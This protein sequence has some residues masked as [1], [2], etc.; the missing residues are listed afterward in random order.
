[1]KY[2]RTIAQN[3]PNRYPAGEGV[4]DA[5]DILRETRGRAE[6]G[7]VVVCAIGPLVNLSNFLHPAPD[8][9]SPLNG[10]ELVRA[11]V[12]RLVV[13]GGGWKGPEWNFQMQP[14][15]AIVIL[16]LGIMC[17]IFHVCHPI[18]QFILMQTYIR[19]SY[20]I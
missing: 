11:K 10:L 15:A 14:K 4:P 1:M 7:S 12:K 19:I 3:Y 16:L 5:S 2:N 13:M 8:G 20:I 9:H 6:D 18:Q 17:A